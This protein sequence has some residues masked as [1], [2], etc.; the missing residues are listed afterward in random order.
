MIPTVT[1]SAILAASF[2]TAKFE[3]CCLQLLRVS[4]LPIALPPCFHSRQSSHTMPSLV[5]EPGAPGRL[6]LASNRMPVTI[7]KKDDGTYDFSMSSG[8]LATGLSGLSKSTKFQWYGWPGIEIPEADAGP[9]VKRLKDEYDAYPVMV[10]DELAERHYNGF[11]SKSNCCHATRQNLV[12][13]S[14][15]QTL[16][17]GLFSTTTPVRSPSTNQRG[18]HTRRSTAYLPRPWQRMYKTEI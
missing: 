18:L 6:L 11:S 8:G 12:L 7:K 15:E 5:Q 2:P 4:Q 14:A 17:S 9:V 13:I 16:S 1:A 10:D 3:S